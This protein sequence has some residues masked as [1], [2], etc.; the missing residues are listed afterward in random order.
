M[1]LFSIFLLS[2]SIYVIDYSNYVFYFL[3][4]VCIIAF[5]I[6]FS[7]PLI[8]LIN[9]PSL[10][11]HFFISVCAQFRKEL[12]TIAHSSSARLTLP[13]LL[14]RNFRLERYGRQIAF[15]NTALI[16]Q[17]VCVCLRW[18]R[19]AN[20]V[21]LVHS[22]LSASI[23]AETVPEM[24]HHSVVGGGSGGNDCAIICALGRVCK[25]RLT[26]HMYSHTHAHGFRVLSELSTR[27]QLA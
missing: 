6:V 24:Q 10:L 8:L 18:I 12:G 17:R 7:R 26:V 22:E 13:V 15:R 9:F 25:T 3:I 4:N 5:L 23:K 20:R 19:W 1:L 14:L 21:A 16:D 27:S 11:L 2:L